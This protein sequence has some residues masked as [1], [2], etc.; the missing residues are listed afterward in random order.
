MY[1]GIPWAVFDGVEIGVP[2][3]GA[4][5]GGGGRAS[6]AKKPPQQPDAAFV[7]SD[8]DIAHQVHIKTETASMRSASASVLPAASPQ[9]DSRKSGATDSDSAEEQHTQKRRKGLERRREK[10]H[11]HKKRKV[12]HHQPIEA[13]AAAPK[14]TIP[15]F[16]WAAPPRES[17]GGDDVVTPLPLQTLFTRIDD[18]DVRQ[19]R[20][21]DT[22]IALEQR[23]HELSTDPHHL[24]HIHRLLRQAALRATPT[25]AITRNEL[26][27]SLVRPVYRRDEEAEFRPP[28]TGERPCVYDANCEG[29]KIPGCVPVTLK[30]SLTEQE[31]ETHRKTGKLP[32]GRRPCKMCR[33]KNIAMVFLNLRANCEGI[34]EDAI[35][36]EYFN[37]ADISGEYYSE[38]MIVTSSEAYQGLME[39]VVLH[40]RYAYTQAEN[41][42]GELSYIQ[43]G[44]PKPKHDGDFPLG[45]IAV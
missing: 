33:R 5:R 3:R 40:D 43:S 31:R 29:C 41:E 11:R 17:T 38:N 4:K 23:L 28:R 21:E 26:R 24:P 45:S 15:P 32:E 16:H 27:A 36:S 8:G 34:R 1:K 25:T 44:Y 2:E 42:H 20:S 13:A 12:D 18:K 39:P 30:E 19:H 7:R 35:I 9:H 14:E 22:K 6:R 37:L 10:T